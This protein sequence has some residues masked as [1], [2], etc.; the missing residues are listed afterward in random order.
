ML[1]TY[2]SINAQMPHYEKIRW[3]EG[4]KNIAIS[5]DWSKN[6]FYAYVQ[7]DKYW[8][9]Q[10]VFTYSGNTNKLILFFDNGDKVSYTVEKYCCEYVWLTSNGHTRRYQRVY[11]D[12]KNC[13]LLDPNCF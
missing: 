10:G 4:D 13:A 12:S 6:K 2:G 5:F 7:L 9:G 8:S 1:L 11:W 3:E